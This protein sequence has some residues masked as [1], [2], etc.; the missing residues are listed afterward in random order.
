MKPKSPRLLWAA[1]TAVFA[2]TLAGGALLSPRPAAQAATAV[3]G[4]AATTMPTFSRDVAPIL[5]QNC[6]TCH[7]TD[8]VAPFPLVTYGDARKRAGQI[9]AVVDSRYMPPWKAEPGYGD[10]HG[11]R[12]LP[13][14]Q[15]ATLDRWASAGAPEG[16]P[17]ALPPLP[18][19]PVGWQLGTPDL[20]VKMP[21]PFVVP[22][23]G[24]DVQQCFVV[25]VSVPKDEYVVAYEFRP[26]DAR[27]V[28]HALFYTDGSGVARQKQAASE[29]D[30]HTV[31]YAS[32][33]GPGFLP[34]S[35]LGAWVP[36]TTPL[37]LPDGIAKLLPQDNDIVIQTHFHPT[38]KA[39][40]EQS[41]LGIYF[42]K[43]PPRKLVSGILTADFA[44]NIP[45]G[46][47]SY[48]A[49]DS[50]VVPIAVEAISIQPHAH[51]LCRDMKVTATLPDGTTRPMIWIK[52]WDWN[53]QGAYQYAQP[54]HLP[55]GTRLDMAYTYDNSADNLHNPNSPPKWV[56]FG[57]QTRDEMALCGLEV[58]ADSAADEPTLK[59]ALGFHLISNFFGARQA[60]SAR[61]AATAH[62]PVA[63]ATG[64]AQ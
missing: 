26:S 61:R 5:Y 38:G 44:M 45:P 41:S 62:A 10:F 51:L 55:A 15:I 37:P 1:A 35:V 58:V 25:P 49:R 32:F 57:E 39:E 29:A 3:K 23:D 2:G 22:A 47:K 18:R 13:A 30:G 9:A 40:T 33:G 31:G 53:W 48:V 7:R 42:A 19:F 52:D 54:V 14:A 11:A 20:I 50:F 21:K 63:Q 24:P 36:G 28:H 34:T 43:T 8:Q 6:T 12:R 60:R 16:D 64:S 27:V 17:S 59:Q 4:D 46:A 56:R